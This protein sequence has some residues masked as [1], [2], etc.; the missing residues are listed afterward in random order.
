MVFE[1]WQGQNRGGAWEAISKGCDAFYDQTNIP[2]D[3]GHRVKFKMKS[4]A[5]K[6][7]LNIVP[8]ICLPWQF[9]KKLWLLMY[10]V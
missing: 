9:I 4:G 2:V 1:R 10:S 8:W 5:R 6:V 7:L 3:K